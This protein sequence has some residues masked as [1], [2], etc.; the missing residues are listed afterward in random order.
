MLNRR[1][2]NRGE[3]WIAAQA[4]PRYAASQQVQR[5]NAAAGSYFLGAASSFLVSSPLFFLPP[6]LPPFLPSSFFGGS[7]A[8]VTA[9][10]PNIRAMPSIK[11]VIFFMCALLLWD[12][13]IWFRL[14][15]MIP[16]AT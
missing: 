10:V 1:E 13:T 15:S 8:N 6:F 16:E 7:W 3:N 2:S 12:K 4:Y 5:Q 11:V 9:T 14:G